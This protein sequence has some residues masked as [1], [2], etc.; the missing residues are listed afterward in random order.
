MNLTE[1]IRE[2]PR[3]PGCY[4]FKDADGVVIY[5]GKSK[6]LRERVKQYFLPG[7]L[8]ED[9]GLILAKLIADVEY[10][11]TKT[12]LDALLLEYRLI[13]Q[14]R[15]WFN[16]QH[17]YDLPQMNLPEY[18]EELLR[19]CIRLDKAESYPSLVIAARRHTDF[20]TDDE[21]TYLG[22]FKN[23]HKAEE[24]LFLLNRVFGTPVCG[25]RLGGK[26]ESPCLHY[27]V[28]RCLGPC[29]GQISEAD[30]GKVIRRVSGVF[31]G[32]SART[33]RELE[34]KMKRHARALEYEKAAAVK[35][36]IEALRRVAHSHAA[37]FRIP[38]SGE[39]VVFL[40]AYGEENFAAFYIRDGAVI[41][42]RDYT[43]K[44]DCF[45]LSDL[46]TPEE[47]GS[48][49]EALDRMLR[50]AIEHILAEKLPVL[51]PKRPSRD[52]RAQ[53]LEEKLSDWVRA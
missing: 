40:R 11:L 39:M 47:A 34:A 38:E 35:A 28:G 37:R 22:E 30:Y 50:D 49:G 36:D 25:H 23:A 18:S 16:I 1:K 43:E 41:R 42:R 31:M 14:Y 7:R 20:E 13:K 24:A 48:G 45:A 2:A 19:Y 15:P 32:K 27:E 9:R 44:P 21:F 10:R 33:F 46:L 4:L 3:T 29:T 6:H 52:A 51:L 5:V 12:D 53:L 8:Q 26:A 17:K